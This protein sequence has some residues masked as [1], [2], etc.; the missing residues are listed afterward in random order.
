MNETI[1]S[2]IINMDNETI[3]LKKKINTLSKD[4]L[5]CCII[6]CSI[7]KGDKDHLYKKLVDRYNLIDDKE[8]KETLLENIKKTND[9]KN[10]EDELIFKMEDL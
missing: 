4:L 5:R 3:D 2:Y 9:E 6:N 7:C 1:D 8:T 10:K